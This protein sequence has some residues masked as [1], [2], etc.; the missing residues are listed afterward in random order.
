MDDEG[1][2]SAEV[3]GCHARGEIDLIDAKIHGTFDVGFEVV[4]ND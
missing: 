2:L 3:F 1:R 4:A